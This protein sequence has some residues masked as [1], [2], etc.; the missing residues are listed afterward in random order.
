[1]TIRVESFRRD[2]K[3]TDGTQLESLFVLAGDFFT[4][5]HIGLPDGGT[6]LFQGALRSSGSED[7]D[8]NFK[9]R[10]LRSQAGF[11][12]GQGN[13][14][15]EGKQPLDTSY[16]NKLRVLLDMEGFSGVVARAEVRWRT[17]SR[18]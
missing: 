16:T 5:L 1:M 8:I 2:L 17:E 18:V 11:G 6:A 4:W 3:I 10:I 13:L 12:P 15:W 14:I 9:R 7:V